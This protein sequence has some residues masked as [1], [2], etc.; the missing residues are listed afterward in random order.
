M[1]NAKN[2][3]ALYSSH[4]TI[5]IDHIS[6]NEADLQFSAVKATGP[7]GQHVNATN[8]AI[9][10]KFDAKACKSLTPPILARLKKLAGRRMTFEGVIL[11]EVREVRSQH[12][13]RAIAVEKLLGMIKSALITP[14]TRRET[15][16]TR[17]SVT[18]RLDKKTR[19]SQKKRT[20]GRV[21]GED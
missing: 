5:L 20:R 2:K 21:R 7:G 1:Y 19:A 4:M 17:G 8:S 15:K 16:P 13:N 6:L 9:Q 14:K 10:L 11:L 12:R 18:R 3:N